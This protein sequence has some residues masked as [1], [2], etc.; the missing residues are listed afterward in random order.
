VKSVLYGE[1]TNGE[2]ERAIAEGYLA[3]LPAGCTEQHGPHLPVD[4]DTCLVS[5]LLQEALELAAR[6]RGVKALLLPAIPYG[7]AAEHMQFAA[8]ISL[9]P[10]THLAVVEDV[11]NSLVEHG[12]TKLWVVSGCGGHALRLAARAAVARAAKL[13]RQVTIY[14]QLPDYSGIARKHLGEDLRDFHAGEFET[15]LW[16]ARR[17]HLVDRSAIP[18][19]RARRFAPESAWLM[20]DISECGATGNPERATAELGERIW[21]DLVAHLVER[22]VYFYE[23]GGSAVTTQEG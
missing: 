3:I 4:T 9:R 17:P 1:L 13:G 22:I 11:L 7:T 16:L 20:K 6:E 10:E 14:V 21:R 8:T 23:G 19:V 15:S 2:I 12:F 18:R 5:S